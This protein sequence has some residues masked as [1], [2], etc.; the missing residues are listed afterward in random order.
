MVYKVLLFNARGFDELL[1]GWKTY[2]K[3]DVS[4]DKL[5]K[6]GAQTPHVYSAVIPGLEDDLWRP[7]AAALHVCGEAVVPEA[8]GPEIDDLDS[9]QLKV[10]NHDVFGLEIAMDQVQA[11]QEHQRS[12]HL[13]SAM[14]GLSPAQKATLFEAHFPLFS[15]QKTG[16]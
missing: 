12:Q 10:R 6:D 11:M 8:G 7:V 4:S 3:Q 1:N 14:F 15:Q 9:G 5:H 16:N 2:R 13:H